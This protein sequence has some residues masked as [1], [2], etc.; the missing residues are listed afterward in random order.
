[1]IVNSLTT[2]HTSVSLKAGEAA[3]LAYD[4]KVHPNSGGVPWNEKLKPIAGGIM[5][6]CLILCVVALVCAAAAFVFGKVSGNARAAEV[7]IA[8]FPWILLGAGI[9]GAASA[10][11]GWGSTLL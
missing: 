4:P 2:L 11:V 8:A 3:V 10:L 1:M 5:V 6:T 9:M 7:S